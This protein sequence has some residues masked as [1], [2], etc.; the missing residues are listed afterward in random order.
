MDG[1]LTGSLAIAVCSE[2]CVPFGV[3]LPAT[4]RSAGG[5][6]GGGR[7]GVGGCIGV[8]DRMGGGT[9]IGGSVWIISSYRCSDRFVGA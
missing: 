4:A 5:G 6:G 9:L 2:R 1:G 3:L 7:T 8:G